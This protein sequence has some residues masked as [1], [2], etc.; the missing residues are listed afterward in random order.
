VVRYCNPVHSLLLRRPLVLRSGDGYVLM[1]RRRR[2]QSRRQERQLVPRLRPRRAGRRAVGTMLAVD[3]LP[4]PA[5]R[6]AVERPG[7][8]RRLADLSAEP[9]DVWRRTTGTPWRDHSRCG[10]QGA[11]C[12]RI[13]E[14]TGTSPAT[15]W[16]G[17]LS[18]IRWVC[19]RS[20]QPR[21]GSCRRCLATS[22]A[23]ATA[24]SCLCRVEATS[25]LSPG[26]PT[27]RPQL[28]V[29]P[30]LDHP[31]QQAEALRVR[32]P[33]SSPVVALAGLGAASAV[34]G[35]GWVWPH[36][37]DTIG[38]VVGGL[39][40][41][42]PGRGLPGPLAARVPDQRYVHGCV[43]VCELT[44]VALVVTASVLVVRYRRPG[45]ARGGMATRGGPPRAR[46]TAAARRDGH[47]PPRPPRQPRARQRGPSQSRARQS[48]SWQR[49]DD[50][51]DGDWQRRPGPVD[52]A[53]RAVRPRLAAGPLTP[54]RGIELWVR[55]NRTT[56]VYGEQGSGK[57]LDEL[58]ST[59]PLPTLRVRMANERALGLFLRLRRPDLETD[60][61]LLRR[62]RS[63]R[64]VRA[65]QQ[66]GRLR[67]RQG[68]PLLQGDLRAGVAPSPGGST[69]STRGGPTR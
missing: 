52:D 8:H 48:R 63:P 43:A 46:R 55:Y 38:Q 4:S 58:P 23:Q 2:R 27:D 30:S 61:R 31:S 6:E 1:D 5:R 60:G 17:P 24:A 65:D 22:S 45:D 59:T 3:P 40:S 56:G 69:P 32:C 20:R 42:H 33:A 18:T 36:G 11:T 67:R 66:P 7:P 41:G 14:A 54:P 19:G 12:A 68:R 10:A 51:D 47:H 49:R 44:F 9:G 16:V 53:G 15:G 26:A 25:W 39:A 57:T 35:G 37:T 50:R 34:V 62:G 13:P 28:R 64:P 21:N 29:D